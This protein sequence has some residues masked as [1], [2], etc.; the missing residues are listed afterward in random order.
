MCCTP[1]SQICQNVNMLALSLLHYITLHCLLTSIHLHA[2][3]HT[4]IEHLTH[5]I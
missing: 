5:I 3:S 4:G 2:Y 1:R